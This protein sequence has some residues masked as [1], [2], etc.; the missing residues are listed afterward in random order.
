M[1]LKLKQ[2]MDFKIGHYYWA[3]HRS[4]TKPVIVLIDY[5]FCSDTRLC[6]WESGIPCA[7]DQYT[8]WSDA[9][10]LPE[11]YTMEEGD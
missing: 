9:I 5:E 11:P 7:I 8:Y 2:D 3:Q 4:Q 10:E 6:A 1:K